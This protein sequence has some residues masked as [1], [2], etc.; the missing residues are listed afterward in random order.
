MLLLE[1][2]N[3]SLPITRSKNALRGGKYE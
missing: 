2:I 1:A 3:N